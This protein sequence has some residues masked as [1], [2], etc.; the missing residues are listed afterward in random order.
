[1]AGAKLKS[2]QLI[3]VEPP[4]YHL[5]HCSIASLRS[6]EFNSTTTKSLG[7]IFLPTYVSKLTRFS[8]LSTRQTPQANH[9]VKTVVNI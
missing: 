6:I 4:Q 7:Q 9:A 8:L 3:S 2:L 5:L 1:V